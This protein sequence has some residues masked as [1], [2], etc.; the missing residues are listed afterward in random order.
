MM[1]WWL[2][3]LRAIAPSRKLRTASERIRPMGVARTRRRVDLLDDSIGISYT[4]GT[5][6]VST[7][8]KTF[9]S[10]TTSDASNRWPPKLNLGSLVD[11]GGA[12]TSQ[13][14]DVENPL[15]R[16]VESLS[17]P[18]EYR[19]PQF[20]KFAGL[21]GSQPAQQSANWQPTALTSVFAMDALGATA[22]S[23]CAPTNPHASLAQTI[24]ELRRDGLPAIP[25]LKALRD[26]KL[27]NIGGE[28]LN[29]EFGWRPLLSDI[30]KLST[31][32]VESE[33]ILKRYV[34]D[35][36][37]VVRRSYKFP[38]ETTSTI[39]NLGAAIPRPVLVSYLY[40]S[41]Y[42][43]LTK[44]QTIEVKKWF[45]GAFTYMVK[46]PDDLWGIPRAAQQANHLLGVFPTPAVLYDLTPWSWALDWFG[47]TG[48]VLNNVSMMLTDGLVMRYGYVMTETKVTTEYRNVG[49]V[50][51]PNIPLDLTQTLVYTSKQR[52]QATPF[53]FGLSIDALS[54]RQIAIVAALGLAR[55]GGTIAK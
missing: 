13:K 40:S 14:F 30:R 54:A 24:G 7:H 4:Y 41:V 52:R 28:H 23:N 39:T 38:V 22:I 42:G 48:D 10:Q 6:G 2:S 43:Q 8:Y 15:P 55:G 36:G 51:K 50:L 44:I 32:V 12:F 29:I 45:S 20:A 47:N 9:S 33:K 11:I 27:P 26:R 34:R 5:P 19:G 53:G 17:W 16:M 31:A 35:S 3:S 18:Y 21:D 1:H 37:K 46:A 49:C 25:G